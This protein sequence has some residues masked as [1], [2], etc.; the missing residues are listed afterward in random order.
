[1]WHPISPIWLVSAVTAVLTAGS[2]SATPI[3]LDW[4]DPW[5]LTA[6]LPQFITHD[7]I[8]ISKIEAISKFRSGAGHDFTDEYEASGRSMKNYIQP[9]AA[10]RDPLGTNTTLNAY[11]PTSGTIVSIEPEQYILSDGSFAGYQVDIVPDGYSMFEVRLFHV[12][13]AV[14]YSVGD[15]VSAG[16]WLGYADMREANDTDIAVEAVVLAT[17]IFPEPGRPPGVYEDR[18]VKLFSPFDLMT[19]ALFGE[20]LLRGAT[21]RSDFVISQAY[22]DANPADFS[23]FNPDD[24]VFLT[25]SPKP[26]PIPGTIALF[27]TGL[28]LL[29]AAASIHRRRKTGVLPD[30]TVRRERLSA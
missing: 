3:D 21:S 30:L 27:A 5:D 9:L 10:Y 18:G 26:I 16:D 1:M 29:L 7:Y 14:G 20:Y 2:A 4:A 8:D 11:A 19:D 17:P 6:A 15:H 24:W 23:G 12:N 25:A 22:R 13:L 28:A